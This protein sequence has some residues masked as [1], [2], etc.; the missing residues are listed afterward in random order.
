MK[1][2]IHVF[3]LVLLRSCRLHPRLLRLT[4]VVFGRWKI[5]VSRSPCIAIS[6]EPFADWELLLIH[7]SSSAWKWCMVMVSWGPWRRHWRL[8]KMHLRPGK[9]KLWCAGALSIW[10]SQ[11]GL[12]LCLPAAN[13]SP[14]RNHDIC[15]CK[16]ND[17]G[18]CWPCPSTHQLD[19][20]RWRWRCGGCWSRSCRGSGWESKQGVA[21]LRYRTISVFHHH[22]HMSLECKFGS[23]PSISLLK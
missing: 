20:W 19:E 7:F 15:Y 5:Y 14:T 9:K 10:W 23:E 3:L 22:T 16:K 13:L 17:A 18:C 6:S 11:W 2:C 1:Y 4:S 12:T 8:S 21:S